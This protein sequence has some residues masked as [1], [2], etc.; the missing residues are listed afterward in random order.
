M[1][2]LPTVAPRLCAIPLSSKEADAAMPEFVDWSS[3]RDLEQV[4]H[5]AGEVLETGGWVAFPTESG[6][7]VAA[8]ADRPEALA[9]IPEESG[10]WS[11]ALAEAANLAD[12]VGDLSPVARRLARRSWP[13]PVCFEFA[14]PARTESAAQLHELVR[15]RVGGPAVLA[16]R[17]PAHDAIL[18]VL[19][20]CGAPLVLGEPPTPNSEWLASLGDAVTLVL[21]DGPPKYSQPATRARITGGSWTIQSAGVYTEADLR[22]LTACVVLFVCTGNTCRSPMAEALFKKILADRLGCRIE[23][24]TQ[25]GWW[26][27]SAGVAAALGEPAAPEAQ[28]A[29]AALGADLTNHRSRALRVDLA[30]TAD[31]LVAMTRGHMLSLQSGFADLGAEP[32]LLG[33]NDL[34]D[35]LGHDQSVY[36]DCARAIHANLQRLAA[37]VIPS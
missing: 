24:L 37:E 1:L 36:D 13:G 32:R 28:H 5:R 11:L 12:W 25:R 4:Y 17:R 31:Y 7:A 14:A 22:S 19:A 27:T 29:V 16:L 20:T 2:D 33:D 10:V 26:V 23:E 21:E 9:A 3:A 18:D 35:P 30:S 34:E 8:R 15:L 6:H